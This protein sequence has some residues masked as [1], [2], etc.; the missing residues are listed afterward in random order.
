MRRALIAA[1]LLVAA[2]NATATEVPCSQ[3]SDPRLAQMTDDGIGFT[4]ALGLADGRYALPA[5]TTPTQLVVMFHGHLND[6]CAWRKHLQDAAARGAVAFAIDYVRQTP[7][8]NYGWWMREA[9]QT[10]I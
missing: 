4:S 5:T 7:I 6:S 1:A 8:E 9:A 2:G 10:S 3:H